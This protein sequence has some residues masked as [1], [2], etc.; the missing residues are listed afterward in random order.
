MTRELD[1]AVARVMGLDVI[2]EAWARPFPDGGGGWA[3]GDREWE[4][5]SLQPVW[6]AHCVCE[7]YP[8][9]EPEWDEDPVLGHYPGC[10]DVVSEYSA[11]IAAAWRVVEWMEKV[12]EPSYML[13]LAHHIDE[14]A[15]WFSVP[16]NHP[17]YNT[18][19]YGWM[20]PTECEAICRAFLKAMEES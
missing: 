3:V 16:I 13:V 8:S 4:G 1:A 6:V 20:A 7:F 9:D 11:D 2:G 12:H 15:A 19:Q 14:W 10:F 17:E 18:R 5:R